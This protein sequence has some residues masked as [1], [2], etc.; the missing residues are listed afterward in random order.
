MLRH[1][2]ASLLAL[3]KLVYPREQCG[4]FPEKGWKP[5]E[6]SCFGFPEVDFSPD[7]HANTGWSEHDPRTTLRTGQLASDWTLKTIEGVEHVFSDHLSRG[8][9]VVVQFGSCT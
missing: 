4:A 6:P 8:M 7:N 9:P 3:A 2:S 5:C 1:V